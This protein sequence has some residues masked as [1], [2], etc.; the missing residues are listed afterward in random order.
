MGEFRADLTTEKDSGR[1]R[2]AVAES[3]AG[4]DNPLTCRKRPECTSPVRSL[5]ARDCT[6]R[7]ERLASVRTAARRPPAARAVE[8]VRR[9]DTRRWPASNGR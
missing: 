3:V 4:R 7:D 9:S 8:A 1:A 6:T 5:A 2:D